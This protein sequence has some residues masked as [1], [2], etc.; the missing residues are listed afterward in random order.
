MGGLNVFRYLANGTK[1]VS[2]A[3]LTAPALGL[4]TMPSR[5]ELMFGGLASLI[6]PSFTIDSRLSTLID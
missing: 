5:V 6:Y 3:I 1:K 2:G 4:D